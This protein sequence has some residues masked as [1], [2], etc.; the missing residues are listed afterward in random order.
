MLGTVRLIEIRLLEGPNVYRLMPVVKV[1]VAVGR[2][3][4]W[5]GSRMPGEGAR[6]LLARPVPVREWPDPVAD[7]V[8]WTRRLR[9]DNGEHAG[10]VE[11]HRAA[12]AGRWV[13]TWPWAGA[14]RA[15]LVAGAAV[16]LA[17]RSVSPARRV[18][19]TMTQAKWLDAW[20]ERIA[21]AGTTPP[22]WV[23]DADRG[24][25]VVSVTGTNGKTTVTRLI[26]HILLCAG[27]HVGATTSDGI[28]VD[29]RLVE[30]GDWTGPGG[31]R[32]ILGRQDVD[33]AVLET[34]RG[35]LVQRGLG[36]ESNEASVFTN[37]SSDHL[38]LGGIHTLP[39]L[40]ELKATVC[41]I[42][43]ADGMVVLNADD[44]LV[45]A[46]AR[47]VR[48]RVGYFSM[49]PDGSA[50]L[51]RH[52]GAGGLAW[53][54]RGSMLI[55]CEGA[56]E[57]PLLDVSDL[58]IALGGLARH[59]VANALAAAGGARAMGASLGEVVEGLRSFRPTAD[60]SPGRL[61]LFRLGRDIVVVDFAHNEA[62]TAAILEVAAAL[63]AAG[64]ARG[65]VGRA[66]SAPTAR[67]IAIIGTAGDRPD[68]SLRG[69]GR[70]AAAGAHR[71]A[72]KETVSYLRGRERADV[73]RLLRD[74][75]AES[76]VDPASVPLYQGETEALAAELAADGATEAADGAT[77]TTGVAAAAAPGRV[78]V[79]L[80]H[81]ERDGVFALLARL[82]ARPVH[83][84]SEL[85]G[86]VRP[87][88]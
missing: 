39:E 77:N 79:L 18:R 3:R 52:R 15:R 37:V 36:Y 72:I 56:T 75:I 80:C 44:P 64:S 7:V 28:L 50:L 6:V 27:R 41:R 40:A 54:L 66:R 83:D 48:A 38:D 61:N 20:M 12:D 14:E 81:E 26:T 68:D 76:G 30:P 11:V 22:A 17:G 9:A 73:V 4:V 86:P 67:V 23:R 33:V 5:H 74:G 43:K 16:D 24:V 88:G 84:L 53:I 63:A 65:D 70:I 58:P 45:A 87:A 51:A 82:G 69:I 62:G 49:A 13:I 55:E 2:T 1:E 46:V 31:A 47:R 25:P 42:T 32:A 59:N 10:P 71:V 85:R 19:L 21:A 60:L 35:G 78:V 8:A 29:E 34:A 57:R